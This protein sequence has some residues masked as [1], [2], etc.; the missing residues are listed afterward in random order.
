M[1]T[2]REKLANMTNEELAEML[3]DANC[4]CCIY[5]RNDF[6]CFRSDCTCKNGVKQWLEQE[7]E[8]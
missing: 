5:K 6:D 1:T 4:H 3:T 2:N 7:S 8:E